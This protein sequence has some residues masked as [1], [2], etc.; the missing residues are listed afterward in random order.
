MRVGAADTEGG[1]GGAAGTG[2][3]GPGAGLGDQVDRADGPVDV[4]AGPVDVQ[5]LR[6]HA[7]AQSLHHLDHP[8]HARGGLGVPEIGLD[9][10]QQQRLRAILAVGFQ[11]GLGLDRVA[12]LGAGAV[13]LHGVH[14]GRDKPGVGQGVRDD[15]LLGGAVGGGQAVGRAVGVHRRAPQ[16]GEHGVAARAGVGQPFQSQNARALAEPGAVRGARERLA[17]AV[18]RRPALAGELQEHAGVG[19]DG[20]ATREREVAVTRTQRPRREVDRDQRR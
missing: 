11:H 4:R 1:H 14:I 12:Q 3:F 9:R 15:P 6:Q 5:R 7:G 17:A 13:R 10:T 8:G 16:D 18:G 2:E 20:D 19:Q